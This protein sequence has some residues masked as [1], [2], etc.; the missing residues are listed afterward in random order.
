MRWGG[1]RSRKCMSQQLKRLDWDTDFLGYPV[2]RLQPTVTDEATIAALITEARRGGFRLLYWSVDPADTKGAST[3][4]GLGAYL[5]DHKVTFA[6]PVREGPAA[7]PQ[8]VEH[9]T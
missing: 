9:T 7:L 5:A 4:Q 8:G 6:M 3:A 1:G 2:G